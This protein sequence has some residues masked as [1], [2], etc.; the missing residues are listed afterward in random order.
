[1]GARLAIGPESQR[2][3][4]RTRELE[5]LDAALG[6]AIA[7][8]GSVVV[9]TGEPGIGKTAL[10][11]A[12]VEH[13][14]ARGASSAW[15]ASWAGGGAPAY[16]PWV[17]IARALTRHEDAATLRAGLGGAA[18]WIAGLLPELA[19]TLGPPAAASDL[20]ADQA[21]FRLFDALV[22][23]LVTVSARRPLVIVL[24]D[25]H[26]ADASSLL[27][28]EFVG[29]A[30]PDL[31][32]L[33]IAAYRYSEA[34]AREDLA[35]ALGGLARTSTRLSLEGLSRDDVGH[36]ATVRAHGLEHGEHTAIAP[37]LVAA[38]HDASAG[39]PFFVDELVQL[40]ASQ[41]RL[42]DE[43]A[44][45]DPLPL[46]EGVRDTLA[47][48]LA[49]L[50]ERAL[51]TLCA[52]AVIGTGFRLGALA[53]VLG[54]A[55]G[56]VLEALDAALRAG[57]V[58]AS[59]D[60]GSYEFVHALVRD[61]LLATVSATERA[62]LHLRTGEALEGLYGDD[63]D[64]HLAEIAHHFLQGVT[65]GGAQRAVDYAAR[66]AQRAMGQFAY[67]EA[68]RLLER[69][70]DV[71]A[72]LPADDLGAWERH[73]ALGEALTRAGDADRAQLVLRDAAEHARRLDDPRHLALTALAGTLP[74]FSPGAVEADRVAVLEE[75]LARLRG[76][77]T[78][79]G[80]ADPVRRAAADALRSRVCVQ[81][82]L[83]LYWSP[84]HERREALVDEALALAR[85]VYSGEAAQRSPAQR[86]LAER[87][88]AFALAQGFL[89]VW[90]PDTVER[91]LPISVEAL[92]LCERT[93]DAELAMQVRLWR[94]SLLLELDDP[95]RADAEIEAYGET[96][97]RL[98]QPRTLVYDPLH[99]AMRAHMHGDL[100]AAGRFTAE[101]IESAREISG[102]MAPLV[103]DA[104]VFLQ[105]RTQGRHHDLEPLLRRNADRLPA[106]RRW[107]CS[108]ALVLAETG[109][110]EEAR[111][112]LEQLA[113]YDF[114]DLPRDV[115]WFVTIAQ[116]AELCTLL[117]DRP[118]AGRLYTLLVPYEGRNVVSI[119]AAYLGPVARYLGMLAMTIGEDERALGHIETARSAA[120]RVGAR[121]SAVLAALDAAEVL[122]RRG[123]PGD[124]QRGAALVE[125]VAEEAARI[126]MD[127]ASA[128]V[129]SLR[130]RL[131]HA[132]AG[133]PAPPPSAD[134][135]VARL[136]LEGAV[137]RLEHEGR[138]VRLQDAKG[139]VHLATL[140]A[141]PG[142]SIPATELAGGGGRGFAA[143]RERAADLSEELAEARSFN[144]PERVARVRAQ[145]EALAG[146]LAQPGGGGSAPAE[147]A[148]VNV[149][150]AL[151]AALRRIAEHEPELGRQ[152]QSSIR[153][154]ATC[155]YRPDPETQLRWEV[156]V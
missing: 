71:A 107:R 55:P 94:I 99:R 30:L 44:T 51:R 113:A 10:A 111:R 33:A 138:S 84:Q 101:A 61:T 96:A 25:L 129:A 98:R 5:Q 58:R 29:G 54:A 34:H 95:L 56:A 112:E 69:A 153:T 116:L 100:A 12:F 123:A 109:R 97:R 133:R 39:N 23:L 110:V 64:A 114:E 142:R 4:G 135:A 86:V 83:A 151:R 91:G 105:R 37:G 63:L 80:G 65:E 52:S 115:S 79:D 67:Q 119:G 117:G 87:A 38:V 40:L 41:G 130:G 92:E 50:G 118:R 150:R 74:N 136:T 72:G 77:G 137:W 147:R 6:R 155:A 143:Q 27:A 49:P 78:E 154:G 48:R 76:A 42:H 32:I 104:Q 22:S 149:T 66:A 11:L 24:D 145:L 62:R 132:A 141:S 43:D 18:P 14:S 53:R 148:R 59:R 35:P 152:L 106:M 47:Q 31:P 1:V 103:A 124:A 73:Q 121:P 36:L 88:L 128:R 8:R 93:N 82:A 108:L 156:C 13:A 131:E 90:G 26:W 120:Q 85:G 19:G 139:L 57:L 20:N 126:G 102:S 81:L 3:V 127:D 60:P 45:G 28:L 75:A 21:R 7:G 89:A 134:V 16:W 140:L 15:G 9:V 70:I 125:G 46:P 17:Q 146:E 144:D 2:L 122:A 68:A